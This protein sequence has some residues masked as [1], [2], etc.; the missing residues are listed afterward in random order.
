MSGLASPPKTTRATY[1]S[2]CMCSFACTHTSPTRFWA[3]YLYSRPPRLVCSVSLWLLPG[4]SMVPCKHYFMVICA[5]ADVLA[6]STTSALGGYS[7][8]HRRAC[9][10]HIRLCISVKLVLFR[11]QAKA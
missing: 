2:E 1:N 5:N 7:M 3:V 4:G 9:N 6:Y 8:S 11:W 10:R